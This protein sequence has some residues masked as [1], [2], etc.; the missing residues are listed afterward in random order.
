MAKKQNWVAKYFFNKAVILQD[1]KNFK[2]FEKTYQIKAWN[3]Y[4]GFSDLDKYSHIPMRY[5][6]KNTESKVRLFVCKS[7]EVVHNIDGATHAVGIDRDKPFLE[8]IK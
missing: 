8:E 5:I 6:K 3:F 4:R 1:F 2:Q 7:I